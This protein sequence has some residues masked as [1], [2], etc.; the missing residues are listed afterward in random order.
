[1]LIESASSLLLADRV[2]SGVEVTFLAL[3]ARQSKRCSLL[4]GRHE[5]SLE[6]RFASLRSIASLRHLSETL[7]AVSQTPVAVESRAVPADSWPV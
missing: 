6:I 5:S 2:T 4:R 3:V 1:M 7:H